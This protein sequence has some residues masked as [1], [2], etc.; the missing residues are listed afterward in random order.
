MLDCAST[1]SEVRGILYVTTES[2]AEGPVVDESPPSSLLRDK[3][4]DRLSSGRGAAVDNAATS[5]S[6]TSVSAINTQC[7]ASLASE[8]HARLMRTVS[9][10]TDS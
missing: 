7:L 3:D 6:L 10:V 2:P 1:T 5:A 9:G 4:Y 8:Q